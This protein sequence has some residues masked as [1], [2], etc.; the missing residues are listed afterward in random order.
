MVIRPYHDRDRRDTHMH[1]I[2]PGL[3]ILLTNYANFRLSSEQHVERANGKNFNEEANDRRGGLRRPALVKSLM[4]DR[5]LVWSEGLIE[6]RYVSLTPLF[7]S[8]NY[9]AFEFVASEFWH[10]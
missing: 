9:D 1:C 2:N 6:Q 8:V 5:S 10:V 7:S 3:D 4:K